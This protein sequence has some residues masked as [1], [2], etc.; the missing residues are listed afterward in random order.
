VEVRRNVLRQNDLLAAELRQEFKEAGV[1]AVGLVS[2]PGSGKTTFLEKMLG[3]L[4]GQRR[5]AALVGDLA[6]ENDAARLR[7]SGAPVEQIN[8]GTVCHLDASMVKRALEGWNLRDLDFLF[9]EN[10]GN[11]VC[12]SSY[13]LGENRRLVLLSVTEG[14]DKPLK[15]P[16]IFNTADA[17]V[18]TKIDLAAAVEFDW[19]AALAN[20]QAVRPGMK[21]LRVSA[22]TGEG[23]DECQQFL[24][25]RS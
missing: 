11:L 3:R 14:E 1:F 12:P 23:M 19:S 8:T 7:R 17:A 6:T 4:G 24:E 22:K 2:S 25:Q 13:D 15:Y 16:T 20:I 5:V 18:I 21:V 10:V 9:I